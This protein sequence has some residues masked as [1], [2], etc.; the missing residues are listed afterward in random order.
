[1]KDFYRKVSGVLEEII[2]EEYNLELEAPFWELPPRPG[3][4]DLS[5]MAGLKLASKLK[6]DPLSIAAAIKV[7]LEERL[8]GEVDK[9]EI[10]KPG[11]INL[12]ISKDAL[13]KS[14]NALLQDKDKFFRHN[15]QNKVILEF[16]SANP[17]GPLS[18]PHGR[19][20][21]VGDVIGNILEFFGEDVVREYYLNDEGR[22]IELLVESVAAWLEAAEGKELKIPEGGY[23]GGYIKDIADK[24]LADKDWQNNK[25]GFDLRKFVLGVTIDLIKKDL[26]SLGVK[27]DS[28]KSQRQL[29]LGKKVQ[30]AVQQLQKKGLIYEQEGALWFASTKFGDD[31]DRV[32][33][34]NDGELTYFASDIAYHKDK[35]DRGADKLIN[36]WGPDHHGYIARVKAAIKAQGRSDDILKIIIIQLVNIKTKERMSRRKGTAILLSDLVNDVGG[37]AARFYYLIR[38]NSSHLEFDIDMAKEASFNNPLYYIQYACARIESIFQKAQVSK[39]SNTKYSLYLNDE[40]E[41]SFLR[42]LFQFSY[43][44]DSAYYTLEPV[45][46]VEYLKN[47]AA[48]LHKFYENKRVLVEDKN[49]T[50]ARLNLLEASRIVIHCGLELLGIKPVKKM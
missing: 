29:I 47:L 23:Q 1:M 22:Q 43:C 5:S 14:L 7:L 48:V 36:L 8:K 27:F 50:G 42:I 32:I 21:V 9:I 44:L 30:E 39:R 15:V 38:K 24:V 46:V 20:A 3:Y 31:K 10:I 19:Q 12:F 33:K 13:I 25:K 37:A 40:E 41:L 11:F 2:R 26:N 28:W 16:V 18:I 35:I 17:T 34:K 6:Q 49:I 45:F 4:G